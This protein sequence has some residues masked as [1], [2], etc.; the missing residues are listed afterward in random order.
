M[1]KL[2]YG[3]VNSGVSLDINMPAAFHFKPARGPFVGSPAPSFPVKAHKHVLI[4]STY[5][6]LLGFLLLK[7]PFLALVSV[8]GINLYFI[9]PVPL[10]TAG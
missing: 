6:Y 10:I 9:I 4:K 2:P 1:L 3:K 7:V 5:I 8:A